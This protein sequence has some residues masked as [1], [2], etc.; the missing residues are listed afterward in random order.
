MLGTGWATWMGNSTTAEGFARMMA[1][2]PLPTDL[3]PRVEAD[4]CLALASLKT[5]T[6]RDEVMQAAQRAV[7]LYRQFGDRQRLTQSLVRYAAAGMAR[8]AD[9]VDAA[10]AQASA[11]VDDSTPTRL[12]AM[13][14]MIR[15]SRA[16]GLHDF[17]AARVAFGRQ[18]ELY[19][20]GG[21]AA[22]EY[23]ALINLGMVAL[24]A[25]EIDEAVATLRCAMDGLRREKAQFN[26]SSAGTLYAVAL[27]VQGDHADV[28]P[29]A[30][31]GYDHASQMGGGHHG[32]K[33][34]MAAALH[35]ARQG[36][37]HRATLIAGH[38]WATLTMRL[39]PPCPLR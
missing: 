4:F 34:L 27:A 22:G 5:Q 3:P 2:W 7:E 26:L 17:D 39:A 16:L 32:F 25:G 29:L 31:Q 1:L 24:D 8:E 23:A 36:D 20:Q 19:R 9:W 14:A 13:V 18:A 21:E 12:R 15:G 33:P 11:L 6:W 38:C 28:L 35:H 30:R 37:G 10:I